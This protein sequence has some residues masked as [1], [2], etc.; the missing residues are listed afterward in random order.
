M[1]RFVDDLVAQVLSLDIALRAC[2]E[3]LAARTDTEA[4]H[5]LRI[6]LRKLRS[7][8]RP[9][10]EQPVVMPLEEAAAALGVL[11][12]PLR[13]LEVLLAELERQG[14]GELLGA[15]RVALEQGY[16]TL[17]RSAELRHLFRVLDNWPGLV[18]RADSDGGLKGLRKRARKVLRRQ[19]ARLAEALVDPAHDRHRLRLLIKRVRYGD[20][21]YPALSPVA[22]D[23]WTAL[24]AAQS[25]LGDWHDHLQWLARAGEQADLAPLMPG[26]QAALAE[27]EVRADKACEALMEHFPTGR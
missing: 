2:R 19:S 27:A 7:L 8:L 9:L 3:R 6:N 18:R 13:D 22:D 25:A 14:H 23:G 17:L 5:D 20:E 4:L 12:G 15:R 21:A 11:S 16:E 1:S 24:K 26:W 10:R